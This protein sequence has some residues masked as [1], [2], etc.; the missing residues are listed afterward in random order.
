M[1]RCRMRPIGYPGAWSRC[2]IRRLAASAGAI[3]DPAPNT[4]AAAVIR[5]TR[6]LRKLFTSAPDISATHY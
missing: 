6:A 5:Q 1:V 3:A 4:V 2:R